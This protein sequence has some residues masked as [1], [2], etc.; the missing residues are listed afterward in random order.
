MGKQQG[1]TEDLVAHLD[2]YHDGPFT[3]REK[4]ALRLAEL[5]ALAPHQVDE[6][7]CRELRQHFGPRQIVQLGVSIAFLYGFGRFVAAFRIPLKEESQDWDGDRPVETG[8]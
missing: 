2:A 1:I 8:S 6:A 7:L 5:L 3:P 4:A